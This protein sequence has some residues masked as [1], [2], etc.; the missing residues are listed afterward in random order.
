MSLL[1]LLYS[2]YAYTIATKCYVTLSLP[3]LLKYR[4]LIAVMQHAKWGDVYIAEGSTE[5]TTVGTLL[6]LNLS[7]I[8]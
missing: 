4:Q 1:L 5:S 8:W 3:V 2:N 6:T 7:D